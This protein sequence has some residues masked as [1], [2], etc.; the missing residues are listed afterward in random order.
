MTSPYLPYITIVIEIV[1]AVWTLFLWKRSAYPQRCAI[2]YLVEMA[3]SGLA[4]VI[5]SLNH[6]HNIW[7]IHL[8]TITEF[9]IIVLMFYLWETKIYKKRII[10]ILGC[11]FVIFWFIAKNT[12]EPFDQM[13]VYTVIIA[14]AIYII[15]AVSL[16]FKVLNDTQ[17]SLKDDARIWIASGLIIYSAG[18]LFVVS[19]F[20]VVN[21]SMPKLLNVIW[22]INW[23]LVILVT[24]F[25]ARGIW[26]RVTR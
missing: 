2:I 9:I 4:E 15:L 3:I 12:F 26:C 19:L 14:Q 24:L 5:M 1:I 23:I 18:T 25:F 22:Y 8:A 13:D 16:L 6:I 21:E 20:N 7:V 17:T 11:L 10:L